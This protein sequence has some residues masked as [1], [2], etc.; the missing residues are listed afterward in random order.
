VQSF[1]IEHPFY[2][3]LM[4]RILCRTQNSER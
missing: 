2:M 3:S 1:E 4:A